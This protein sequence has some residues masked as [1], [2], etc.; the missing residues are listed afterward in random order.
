[1]V[2]SFIAATTVGSAV[3]LSLAFLVAPVGGLLMVG[4]VG[5]RTVGKFNYSILTV[6]GICT[7]GIGFVS[8]EQEID[9][10]QA[11]MGMD[12]HVIDELS[13]ID[14]GTIKKKGIP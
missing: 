3:S 14:W 6:S 13:I 10:D 12:K 4:N 2:L 11:I 5:I 9:A 1:M 8:H 7:I